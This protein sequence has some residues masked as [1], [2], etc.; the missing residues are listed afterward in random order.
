MKFKDQVLGVFKHFYASVER[1]KGK[2][3]KCV[4]TDIDGEYRGPF[5]D[6]LKEN[7]IKLEKILPNMPQ[8]N[9]VANTTNPMI[10]DKIMC[11][12]SHVQL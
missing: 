7:G 3:L 4:R 9:K 2:K 11:M 8:H 12:L 6:Y 10:N 5:E 1:E